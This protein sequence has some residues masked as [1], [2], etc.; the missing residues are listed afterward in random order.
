RDQRGDRDRAETPTSTPLAGDGR[1]R[2]RTRRGLWP[3]P[4]NRPVEKVVHVLAHRCLPPDAAVP[5][6]RDAVVREPR[7]LRSREG[8]PLPQARTP[9]SRRGPPPVAARSAARRRPAGDRDDRRRPP[10]PRHPVGSFGA[11][12]PRRGDAVASG[13]GSGPF[14]RGSPLATPSLG[15]VT[16]ARTA[17]RTPP[18]RGP[19][20][21]RRVR[22]A[23][24][25]PSR[26]GSARRGR[27]PRT[28]SFLH[29]DPRPPGSPRQ[30]EPPAGA[31]RSAQED[32][33]PTTWSTG[34]P[35]VRVRETVQRSP[36]VF[37]RARSN[38]R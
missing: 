27:C 22:S 20:P 8:V 15:P 23:G 11:E 7:R 16:I 18:G 26:A 2:G 35:C 34:Q 14:G 17:S 9:A 12:P 38:L 1:D 13:G 25:S 19:Q 4:P 30:H 31:I 3:V 28:R 24:A 10:R 32:R 33:Y 36:A 21:R 5:V 37:D 6:A 29:P